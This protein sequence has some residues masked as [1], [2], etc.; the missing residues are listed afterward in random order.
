VDTRLE[1]I[2][3]SLDR[4]HTGPV[5]AM[6]D[7]D[8]R[9]IPGKSKGI[10]ARHHLEA[11]FDPEEP[12]CTDDALADAF[13]EAG[14]EL[15]LDI[16]MI[17]TD[18]ER[19]IKVSEDEMAEALK[20]APSE[21]VLGSGT[22]E[23][24]LK[25]RRPEDPYPPLIAVPLAIT[26]SED[27]WV[28]LVTGLVQKRHLADLLQGPSLPTVY[29]RRVRSGTPYET[30]MG[31]YEAELRREALYRAGRPGMGN[32]GIGGATTEFGHLGGMPALAGPGNVT[33]ALCPSELKVH[34][35]SF[36]KVI[37]GLNYG[38]RTRV[39]TPCFIGGYAGTPEGAVVLNVA[40][41]LLFTT[42]FACD[43]VSSNIYDVRQ[44]G[45]CGR[46]GVWANSV[47][48]QAVSRNTRLMRTKIINQ[49]AGPVTEMLLYESAVGYMTAS[50]SGASKVCGPRTAGGK[51]QDY[52]TPLETWFSAE[53]LKSCAGMSR[54]Q[55]NEL[56]K[57]LIPRYETEL[58]APPKGKSVQ[59]CFDLV[60]M[61][62]S[63]EWQAMYDR[64]KRELSDLGMP[65]KW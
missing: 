23:V 45:N 5:C 31:R 55:A 63:L 25:A 1:R 10:V 4:A 49:T 54:V 13:F 27:I 18:T 38:N 48:T 46:A 14:R 64:V 57:I 34:F 8:A 60:T 24:V 17:C 52:I 20:E 43:Y 12:I 53:V 22:D 58:A 44:F 7:W 3:R 6:E 61:K 42:V 21:L 56:A 16:G 33:M 59:E 35:S 51:Y 47:A 65:F 2:L 30:L 32:V 40:V 28:P 50:V 29:G 15:A 36:H 11:S 26:V 9:V 37:Q 19:V 39:G 41:D 62:P